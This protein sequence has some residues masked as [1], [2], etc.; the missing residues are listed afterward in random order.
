MRPR[1]LACV[2]AASLLAGCAIDSDPS[3]RQVEPAL[4]SSSLRCNEVQ[5]KSA[6]NTYQKYED[7]F[8]VL[9]Y[10]RIRS[11]E[12]D[13]STQGSPGG[14][15]AP[16]YDWYLLHGFADYETN[17][18]FVSDEMRW[19]ATFHRAVPG[20]EVVTVWLDT[21]LDRNDPGH[22]SHALD[23]FL[24]WYLGDVWSASPAARTGHR[25]S[26]SCMEG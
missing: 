14:S 17:Y 25:R 6:H 18:T 19:L 11:I 10:H 7:I 22:D 26:S 4:D 16:A 1:A 15:S 5:Q 3:V 12:L 13:L 23:A 24:E 21:G 9:L 20:H 2:L 8:D